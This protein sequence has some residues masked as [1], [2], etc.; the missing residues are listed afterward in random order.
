MSNPVNVNV[1]EPVVTV[2]K[3]VAATVTT[4]VGVLTLFVTQVS[5]GVYSWD[6]GGT[7][8]GAVVAAAATIGAVWKTRNK[9]KG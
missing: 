5:D 8:I 1:P 2:A 4:G 3:S 9:V 7:L 6:E